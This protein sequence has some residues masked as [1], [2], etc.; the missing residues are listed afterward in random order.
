MQCIICRQA[1]L[2]IGHTPISFERGEFQIVIKV[3]PVLICPNCK[4]ALVTEDVAIRLLLIAE[5]AFDTG[6]IDSIRDFQST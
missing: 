2:I 3:V 1:E 4:D 6:V 5:E